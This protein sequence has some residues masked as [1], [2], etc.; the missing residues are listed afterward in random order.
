MKIVAQFCLLSIGI[1]ILIGLGTKWAINHFA[2]NLN[3]NDALICVSFYCLVTC[4]VFFIS[5]LG[6]TQGNQ[7]FV[8][9][10]YAALGL[11]FVSSLFYV[12]YYALTHKTYQLAFIFY[13]MLLFILFIVFEIYILTTKL[14]SDSGR[15]EATDEQSN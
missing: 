5:Y 12:L 15:N 10:S 2:I 14:R 3:V 9:F 1:S 7:Q 8:L 6:K 13:F 11:R 4:L